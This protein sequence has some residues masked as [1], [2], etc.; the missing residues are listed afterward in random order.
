MDGQTPSKNSH[1][2]ILL[3]TD[4]TSN[5]SVYGFDRPSE[6][7]SM[8]WNFDE[9][10]A[11]FSSVDPTVAI[12]RLDVQDR[13]R[14]HV[15]IWPTIHGRFILQE[16]APTTVAPPGDSPSLVGPADSVRRSEP[17]GGSLSS[18]SRPLFRYFV[19]FTDCGV[20]GNENGWF[21]RQ[22]K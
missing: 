12:A 9:A 8:G 11:T 17:T 20:V 5:G 7:A 16:S 6:T 19:V 1:V 15:D 3:K 13:R 21:V 18:A 10:R 4:L 2:S 14:R 22:Q